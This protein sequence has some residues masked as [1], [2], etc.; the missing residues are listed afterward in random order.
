M[1]KS[2]RLLSL[3]PLIVF[4]PS[5]SYSIWSLWSPVLF[6]HLGFSTLTSSIV[7]SLCV[8]A[9]FCFLFES[10]LW[11]RP[12][13][14]IFGPQASKRFPLWND[15]R[16]DEKLA[17]MSLSWKSATMCWNGVGPVGSRT[18]EPVRKECYSVQFPVNFVGSVS[19]HVSN[20][21]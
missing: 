4:F 10:W 1:K 12:I 19:G 5:F 15:H 6:P 18:K 8:C 14:N 20:P 7:L 3:E 2:S 21:D 11:P 16:L 17:Q 13:F 9:I